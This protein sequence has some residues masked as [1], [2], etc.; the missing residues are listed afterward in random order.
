MPMASHIS[1]DFFGNARVHVAFPRFFRGVIVFGHFSLS[2]FPKLSSKSVDIVNVSESHLELSSFLLI[3]FTANK[4]PFSV[5]SVFF[6]FFSLLSDQPL[7]F[8]RIVFFARGGLSLFARGF[9]LIFLF[10][11]S[12]ALCFLLLAVSFFASFFFLVFFSLSFFALFI[13]RAIFVV[14]FLFRLSFVEALYNVKFDS[15]NN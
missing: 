9:F 5:P 4:Y 14:I 11:L 10:V 3:Q 8:F 13:A 1:S 15:V 2:N 7:N 12:L 6:L